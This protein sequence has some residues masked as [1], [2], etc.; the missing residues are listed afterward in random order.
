VLVRRDLT[1]AR[2]AYGA[3]ITDGE[4]G[5]W[6]GLV[7]AVGGVLEPELLPPLHT[8]LGADPVAL[9]LWVAGRHS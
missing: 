5:A 1:A 4:K 9:A 6:A 8:A 3:A 2:G 7:T